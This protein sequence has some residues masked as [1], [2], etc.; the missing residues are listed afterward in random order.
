MSAGKDR[1]T[2]QIVVVSGYNQMDET[3][4]VRMEVPAIKPY[5]GFV[6]NVTP[7]IGIEC[8]QGEGRRPIILL[9]TGFL[10]TNSRYP[11]LRVRVGTDKIRWLTWTALTNLETFK[12]EDSGPAFHPYPPSRL[13][14]DIFAADRLLIEFQPSHWNGT[15]TAEFH[16]AGLRE[17]FD[18]HQECSVK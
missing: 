14:K 6:G 11:D 13:L 18:R 1:P 4:W 15:F 16:P 7:T 9:H 8:S 12:Y 17:E 3:K 10:E 5:P 2:Q